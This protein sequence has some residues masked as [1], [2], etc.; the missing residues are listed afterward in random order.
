MTEHN[1]DLAR[2]I[3]IGAGATRIRIEEYTPGHWLAASREHGAGVTS[4]KD[5]AFDT[6][7]EVAT[8]LV[9]QQTAVSS[10]PD[11]SRPRSDG[12]DSVGAGDDLGGG[13]EPATGH[14]QQGLS[15]GSEAQDEAYGEV[16]GDTETGAL[17]QTPSESDV[18]CGE[19]AATGDAPGEDALVVVLDDPIDAD[20][21]EPEAPTAEL[22]G[23]DL[24]ELPALEFSAEMAEYEEAVE[25]SVAYF[26]DDLPTMRLK[27]MGRLAQIAAEKVAGELAFVNWS[28]DEFNAVQSHVVS[29]LN[30]ATGAYTGDRQDLYNRF[31]ELSEAQAMIATINRHRDQSI[32]YINAADTPRLMVEQFDPETGWP[33]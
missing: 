3:L 21:A 20:F 28:D 26:G 17:D 6:V 12:A 18:G 27:K 31:V 23:D 29:N 13:E 16:G 4:D 30:K 2:E 8:H 24:A 7:Q 19:S 22:E 14:S 32:A 15:E 25:G 10:A 5:E 11:L 9:R 33:G 1:P